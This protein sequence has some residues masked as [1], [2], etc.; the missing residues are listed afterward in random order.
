MS[1]SKPDPVKNTF[2]VPVPANGSSRHNSVRVH[3]NWE[4]EGGRR[5]IS[6]APTVVKSKGEFA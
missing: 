6:M 3:I 4:Q 5:P 1:E 2:A